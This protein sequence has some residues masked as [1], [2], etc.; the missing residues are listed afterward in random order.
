MRLSEILGL[1]YEQ[2]DLKHGFIL[3]DIT[4]NGERREIPIDNTLIKMFN[5]M[6]HSIESIFVF[7]DRNRNPYRSIRRSFS[8]ALKKAE[9]RDFR[10]HDLRHTFASH[11]VMAGVD[12]ISVKELLGHKSLSMTMRYAHLT[13]GHKK[14]AV[15]TLDS[16]L[17]NTQK[18]TPVHNLS[19][20]P[21]L[22]P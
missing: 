11:L 21:I 4:K 7:T 19:K 5:V 20:T 1:R 10:F 8:T 17:K 15:N 12:L 9:I 22:H 13:P 18:E 3:L 16:V 14:K 6:P 2:A